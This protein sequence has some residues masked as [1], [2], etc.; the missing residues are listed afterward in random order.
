MTYR[1]SYLA[2]AGSRYISST[3]SGLLTGGEQLRQ[4]LQR[5]A[6]GVDR[7]EQ[8]A[9]VLAVVPRLGQHVHHRRQRRDATCG[10]A[11][12]RSAYQS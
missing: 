10:E 5:D 12:G 9:R 2:I 4:V 6:Q 11:T 3:S 1:S 8:I 7:A